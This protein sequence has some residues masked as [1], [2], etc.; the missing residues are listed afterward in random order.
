MRTKAVLVH[1]IRNLI[2][3]AV[4][5]YPIYSGVIRLVNLPLLRRLTSQHEITT[6]TLRCGTKIVVDV[7]DYCGRP[8]FFWGDYDK[9]IT[10]LC[11][12]AL[13][14]GDV[15]LDIGANYGEISLA[16]AR[17]V[18]ET[19]SVHAFEPNPR[20]CGYLRRSA[21]LN[22]FS[23]LFIHEIALGE[24]DYASKIYVSEENT[25][26]ASL[27]NPSTSCG[28][29]VPVNVRHAGNYLNG[30]QL[31]GIKVIKLDVEGME[32]VILGCMK[33]ILMKFRPRL[34]LFEN[35]ESFIPFFEREPVRILRELGYEFYQVAIKKTLRRSPS[36][37]PIRC[38]QDVQAGYDFAAVP[39]K[40]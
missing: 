34:I 18:G 27:L 28:I 38:N 11:V 5:R 30:L 10:D 17:C 20:I 16:A 40:A 39:M 37:L 26:A 35:H 33:E 12:N 6:T 21:D 3:A 8:I 13:E 22:G 1:V 24:R 25:G 29:G 36:L 7:S 2:R 4:R 19:G 9:R 15:M 23:N 31:R 32:A 14:P